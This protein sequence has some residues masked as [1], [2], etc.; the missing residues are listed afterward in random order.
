MD[1]M[2]SWQ[3]VATAGVHVECRC[4]RQAVCPAP[5]S[6]SSSTHVQP[7]SSTARMSSGI[8]PSSS[9]AAAIVDFWG[10]GS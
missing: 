5:L 1:N 3:G 10:R 9:N 2:N 6:Q 4:R 8:T 7:R